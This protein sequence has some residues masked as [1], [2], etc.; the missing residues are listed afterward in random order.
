MLVRL[1]RTK[2]GNSA[3]CSFYT[4]A[5][6]GSADEALRR[7]ETNVFLVSRWFFPTSNVVSLFNIIFLTI[8]RLQQCVNCSARN[9]ASTLYAPGLNDE[10][11]HPTFSE[12]AYHFVKEGKWVA[13]SCYAIEERGSETSCY[14]ELSGEYAASRTSC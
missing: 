10:P 11:N 2:M 7:I 3:G 5:N 12:R 6:S 9:M 4:T 13:T 14:C 8:S 1:L